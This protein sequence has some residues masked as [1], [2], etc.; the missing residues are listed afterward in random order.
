MDKGDVVHIETM[1]Y[2]LAIKNNENLLFAITWMDLE[3][4][5][6]KDKYYVILLNCEI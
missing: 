1:P 5:S 2:Y 6:E 3:G 4:E